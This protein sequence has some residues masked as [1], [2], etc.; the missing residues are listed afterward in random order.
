MTYKITSFNHDGKYRGCTLYEGDKQIYQATIG[1][2]AKD[3]IVCLTQLYP[4]ALELTPSN[5]IITHNN[6]E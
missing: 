1:V 6:K 2:Y 3:L 5:L 4:R